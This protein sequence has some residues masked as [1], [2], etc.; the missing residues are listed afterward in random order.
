ML[1]TITSSIHFLDL[2]VVL[3]GGGG[4]A[5]GVVPQGQSESDSANTTVSPTSLLEVSYPM[6]SC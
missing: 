1:S 3:A 5:N 4:Y 2:A 6:L